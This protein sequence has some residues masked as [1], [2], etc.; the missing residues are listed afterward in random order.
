MTD[1]RYYLDTSALVKRY[2]AEEGTSLVDEIYKGAYKGVNSIFFSYWNVAEVAVVFDK[3]QRTLGLDP[4]ALMESFLRETKTLISLNRL[5]LIAVDQK[6][7]ER[8]IKLI[9][10]YH[11]YVADALQVVSAGVR[12]SQFVTADRGLAETARKEGLSVIVVL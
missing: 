12:D 11:I 9:F 5:E 7:M 2:V 1:N 10:K 4:H 3:Y 6:I 8:S